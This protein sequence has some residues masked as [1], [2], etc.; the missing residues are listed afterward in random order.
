MLPVPAFLP[1]P[2][3]S[4]SGF[5]R[6][7]AAIRGG[8]GSRAAF[9]LPGQGRTG[10]GS[11]AFAAQR[12]G[13]RSRPRRGWLSPRR[14]L[15]FRVIALRPRSGPVRRGAFPR[16]PQLH[17]GSPGFGKPDGDR[18]FRVSRTMLAL[19][20]MV[21]FFAD[22]L[23]GLRRWRFPLACVFLRAIQ[24]LFMGHSYLLP[25]ETRASGVP[26]RSIGR[27]REA[28]MKR[29]KAAAL[30]KCT[31]NQQPVPSSSILRTACFPFCARA[32]PAQLCTS[33]L[34]PSSS[35]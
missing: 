28:I 34:S 33:V 24:G 26:A 11:M 31:V 18:L 23:A 29:E 20:N 13:S 7:T 5:P 12:S 10:G 2:G 27:L 30:R 25:E 6:R 19:A 32:Q 15:R 8:A 9:R 21:H 35:L 17:S 3:S 4:A 22:K 1:V 16:R 14:F